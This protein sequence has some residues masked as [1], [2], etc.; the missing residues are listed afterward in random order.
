M[1]DIMQHAVRFAANLRKQSYL[2]ISYK[3]KYAFVG[4]GSHSIDNL[5]PVINYLRVPIQCI[6]TK[7]KDNA[8]AIGKNWSGLVGSNDLDAV[9]NDID[10]FFI[11]ARAKDHFEILKSVLQ[12]GKDAFIE[13]PPCQNLEQLQQLVAIQK[14][15]GA[16]CVVGLQKRYAPGILKLKRDL[17]RVLSYNYRFL[18]GA[19]P[20]GNSLSELFIHSLDLVV[21]LFGETNI[22]SA[23]FTDSRRSMLLHLSHKGGVSKG[24]LHGSYGV[25]KFWRS[26]IRLCK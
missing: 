17:K 3:K 10:A 19:Y 23:Q 14:S 9:I 26:N 5:Y 22:T 24:G 25:S 8:L 12:A 4:V 2:K 18:V 1:V 21:Y 11:C 15:T 16:E 6:V 7:S 13:K 20:E